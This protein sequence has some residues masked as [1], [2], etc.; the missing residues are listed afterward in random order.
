[1]AASR[2]AA[3]ATAFA[4]PS[5]AGARAAARANAR[6]GFA[7][8]IAAT[9]CTALATKTAAATG[10]GAVRRVP[11]PAPIAVPVAMMNTFA[12]GIAD[13]LDAA[14]N[15]ADQCIPGGDSV[16]QIHAKV[17]NDED[18][19]TAIALSLSLS[20]AGTPSAA[21]KK[22]KDAKATSAAE[23]L[24]SPPESSPPEPASVPMGVPLVG[25]RTV[26][27]EAVTPSAVVEPAVET[28]TVPTEPFDDGASEDGVLVDE[29][30]ADAAEEPTWLKEAGSQVNATASGVSA[31]HVI[32]TLVQ[33]LVEMG[34]PNRALNKTVL[35]K[36]E[37]NLKRAVKELV[38]GVHLD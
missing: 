18:L 20:E 14:A 33:D 19:Q 17:E 9:R 38:T 27:P 23:V 4:E 34:F 8:A 25:E 15:K 2:D 5:C 7:T 35:H 24:G 1:M 16:A 29:A 12:R 30:D 36:H 13:F 32:D 22:V 10:E 31:D 3:Y 21:E 26:V 28:E 37:G 11:M 6:A